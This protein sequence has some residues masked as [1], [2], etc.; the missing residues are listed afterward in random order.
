MESLLMK[1][2]KQIRAADL[3][4]TGEDRNGSEGIG[5]PKV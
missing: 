2:E 3:W 4:K 1:V 5:K